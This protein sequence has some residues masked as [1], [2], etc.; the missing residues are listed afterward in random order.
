[1]RDL[2]R[3]IAIRQANK[4]VTAIEAYKKERNDYPKSLSDLHPKYLKSIPSSCIIGIPSYQFQ[5]LDS[6]Y[7]LTFEQNVL[8]GFNFEVVT[9]NPLDKH[10]ADGELQELFETGYKHW[11]YYIFDW[12][13][14][15]ANMRI[16][17]SWAEC[18][19]KSAAVH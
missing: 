7:H 13:I 1:M 14:T 8:F 3:N 12:S 4:I 11:R 16:A 19:C 5:N 6:T 15:A 10:H 17:N 18:W 9:Y 2:S